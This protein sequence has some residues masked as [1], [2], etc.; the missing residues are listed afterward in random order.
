M[1]QDQLSKA[2]QVAHRLLP[3]LEIRAIC[4]SLFAEA[5]SNAHRHGPEK[6]AVH[7]KSNRLRLIVGGLIVFSVEPGRTWMALDCERL[8]DSA[9][10]RVW[11]EESNSWQWDEVEYPTYKRVSSWNGYYVPGSDHSEAW[12]VVR[13]LHFAFVARSASV[14]RK[15]KEA[16]RSKHASAV[17]ELLRR[18]LD[19]P[20]PEPGLEG[21]S[22]KVAPGDGF[23][24]EIEQLLSQLQYKYDVRRPPDER[25]RGR[26]RTGWQ[27]ATERG[28]AYAD[29]TLEQLTW[30]NLGYR[31]GRYFGDQPPEQV[32]Q[33]FELL[34]ESYEPSGPGSN[35]VSAA[36][37]S[38]QQY[39]AAFRRIGSLTDGQIQMLRTHYYAPDRT[40]TATEMARATGHEHY[41]FANS[42]Y[43]RL[44]RL[45]GEQ[46]EYN[47][48][49]ERL[50]TLVTFEKRQGEW[51]WLM[52][53][54]VA[55][56]L[57]SL[58]WVESTNIL[59]EEIGAST[60]LVEG[61]VYR[62]SV[63]AYE[64]NPNARR[65][66]IAYYGP[67][68]FVCDFDFGKAYGEIGVGYIHVHHLRRLSDVGERY[69]VDPIADLRPVC[70]NCHAVIHRRTPPYTVEEVQAMLQK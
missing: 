3:E 59:P 66:C 18:E 54:Q 2:R 50:G 42:Q 64:R 21:A 69:E 60:A 41:S 19:R 14:L 23:P 7:L 20:I 12:P 68:C 43:G 51:H 13:E 4:L 67:R 11:L 17:L 52:R 34:A 1:K 26:F 32:D 9:E 25:R 53:P 36:V 22:Y 28:E 62:I 10:H 24:F 37:P 55:Q 65:R 58:D 57:E 31:F 61:A 30:Q 39:V 56:A 38:S 70:P 45:V 48:M 33:A 46:L 29:D 27:D 8:N 49:Q 44:G 5:I 35:Q 15:I 47:P 6:W 40:I 16:S 63:N